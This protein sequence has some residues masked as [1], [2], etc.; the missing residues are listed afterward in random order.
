MNTT[1]EQHLQQTIQQ[2]EIT[3]TLHYTQEGP[4]LQECITKIIGKHI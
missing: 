1:C 4:T 2:G 3:V